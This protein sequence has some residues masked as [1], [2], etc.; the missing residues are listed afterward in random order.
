MNPE[1]S[2]TDKTKT[3][4]KLF[5]LTVALTALCAPLAILS[6]CSTTLAPAGVYKGDAFLYAVDQTVKLQYTGLQ[7]FVKWEA[8]NRSEITNRWPAVTKAADAVR[9]N[10]PGWFA[11]EGVAR[12][13]YIAAAAIAGGLAQ[14]S[15]NLAAVPSIDVAKSNL[16]HSVD[17]L[18]SYVGDAQVNVDAT[19]LVNRPTLLPPPA[20]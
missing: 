9:K 17:I 8:D 16:T 2:Q 7:T 1:A 13:D 12:A 6:G 20:Q 3:M 15:T 14:S 10:A 11:L 4:K 18:A 5:L 19:T